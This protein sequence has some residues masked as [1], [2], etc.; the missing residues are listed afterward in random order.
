MILDTG[1]STV[2]TVGDVQENQIGIDQSNIEH[3]ISILSTNLYSHPEQSFL[4]EIVSNA[5]DAQVEAESDEPAIVSMAYDTNSFSYIVS[6]RDY[7]TGISPE[8][9]KEIYLNIGS[10]TKRESNDYIGSFGIGRF[11]SLACANMVHITSY[12]EGTQY[13]YVMLKNGSKINIDLVDQSPTTEHNGVEVKIKVSNIDP[14]VEA[15]NYLWFIPNLFVNS[16]KDSNLYFR[17]WSFNERNLCYFN[18]FAYNN[19]PKKQPFIL[20]GH[21]LYPVDSSHI[22]SKFIGGDDLSFIWSHIIPTFN[23]GEL[24]ITPNREQLL[25]SDRTIAALEKRFNEVA[26]E[27]QQLCLS[28]S[29]RS[30]DNILEYYEEQI[31]DV[32]T[33]HLDKDSEVDPTI[34]VHKTSFLHPYI[35][36][37]YK[38]GDPLADDKQVRTAIASLKKKHISEL[39]RSI[40]IF[41]DGNFF[42]KNKLESRYFEVP[43]FLKPDGYKELRLFYVPTMQGLKSEIFKS[44]LQ[45]KAAAFDDDN[46]HIHFGFTTDTP[47]IRKFINTDGFYVPVDGS[48]SKIDWHKSLWLLRELKAL[49]FGKVFVYDVA[50]SKDFIDYRQAI[51]AARREERKNRVH[52]FNSRTR[53][54]YDSYSL[55]GKVTS[56]KLDVLDIDELIKAVKENTFEDLDKPIVPVYWGVMDSP[57]VDTWKNILREHQSFVVLTVAKTNLRYLEKAE[58]PSNW[59]EVTPEMILN[60]REFRRWM[61]YKD[62]KVYPYPIS[63]QLMEEQLGYLPKEVR[64]A[65]SYQL[66]RENRMSYPSTLKELQEQ[67]TGPYDF[68]MLA[69]FNTINTFN[70]KTQSLRGILALNND[71]YHLSPISVYV[72]MKRKLFR[73]NWASYKKIVETLNNQ[74]TDKANEEDN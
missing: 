42:T 31:R 65:N 25:Y 21:I 1:G 39:F 23:I 40:S 5:I 36:Y 52:K 35:N 6:I 27:L 50:N 64:Y 61:T 60:S 41:G 19:T 8:R 13:Q 51:I 28:I 3:I 48:M 10:S 63:L 47:S 49:F 24:D 30:F 2:T 20:L 67:F 14:Y 57:Y 37:K 15:M 69:G 34:T 11:A 12:Y 32:R 55:R 54:Y 18:T 46:S 66:A 62:K 7:G 4:R 38:G 58:L 29:D 68:N 73:P 22:P 43:Y 33:V 9:F 72:A 45:E 71:N 17:T 56:D 74:E 53:F 16:P 70:S 26:E 44:Y 59:I